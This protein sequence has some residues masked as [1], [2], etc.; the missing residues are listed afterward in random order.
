MAKR[1]IGYETMDGK[2][3]VKAED[4]LDYALAAC[5]VTI[6]DDEASEFQDFKEMLEEWYFSNW[7]EVE[8]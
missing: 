7:V 8:E 1:L 3:F 2:L 5:G 4:A 6:V